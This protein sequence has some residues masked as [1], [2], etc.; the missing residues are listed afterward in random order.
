MIG[1][2][3]GTFDPVHQGHL[4]LARQAQEQL[5]LDSIQFMPCASPV[6][7]Q[8]PAAKAGHRLAMLQ[9]VI[10]DYPGWRINSTELD[11]G[12]PSYM[13]DSLRQIHSQQLDNKLC[14]LLGADAFN[15]IQSWR[16]PAEIL[17][18]TH[19][20]VC[21]RPGTELDRNIY[22]RYWIDD[23][24]L[25]QAATGGCILSLDI[26]ENP[27]SST[28]IRHLLGNGESVAD[29]LAPAVIDYINQYQLYG[30]KCE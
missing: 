24:G 28:E 6:H 10:A 3:G 26:A 27:C 22:R 9:R 5:S 4:Q 19:L 1:I 18:L 12:G 14:L 2:F 15:T 11:R 8:R 16:S 13:A 30:T 23:P 29:Y 7:R 20:V 25:L 17:R 21:R